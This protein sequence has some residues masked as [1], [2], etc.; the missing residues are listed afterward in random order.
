MNENVYSQKFLRIEIKRC[1]KIYL[2]TNERVARNAEKKK[3]LEYG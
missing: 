3:N 2:V 1:Y